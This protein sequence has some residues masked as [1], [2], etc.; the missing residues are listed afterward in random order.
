LNGFLAPTKITPQQQAPQTL[1][2]FSNSEELYKFMV[3]DNNLLKNDRTI[4]TSVLK[5]GSVDNSMQFIERDDSIEELCN[6]LQGRVS[7]TSPTKKE[8]N[9]II[10]SS[11]APGAGKSTFIEKLSNLSISDNLPKIKEIWKESIF[12]NVTFNAASELII[13]PNINPDQKYNFKNEFFRR[14]LWSYFLHCSFSEKLFQDYDI[15]DLNTEIVFDTIFYDMKNNYH[16]TRIFLCVDEIA[17]LGNNNVIYLCSELGKMLDTYGLNFNLFITSLD[18]VLLNQTT[19]A[20]GRSISYV[21]LPSL[22]EEGSLSLFSNSSNNITL[23]KM[24]LCCAGHPRTLSL[25]FNFYANNFN[26]DDFNTT[27]ARF[28]Q[29]R[30]QYFFVNEISVKY[31]LKAEHISVDEKIEN[32]RTVSDYVKDGYFLNSYERQ[33]TIVPYT[34]AFA[35]YK[36]A[37]ENPSSQF[38]HALFKIL[39]NNSDEGLGFEVFH[40]CWEILFR[41]V[42]PNK[43]PSYFFDALKDISLRSEPVSRTLKKLNNNFANFKGS[44]RHNNVP[45]KIM[46][47]FTSVIS[48]ITNNPGFDFLIFEEIKDSSNNV[49]TLTLTFEVKFSFSTDPNHLTAEAI[50]KKY[51]DTNDLFDPYLEPYLDKKKEKSD[52]FSYLKIIRFILI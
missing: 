50:V 20:T 27:F 6:Y 44:F 33:N 8:Q 34:S 47:Y 17:R 9:S 2:K 3:K 52:D 32:D 23:R 4:P 39:N 1:K 19:T 30:Y 21:Y 51:N 26:Y 11:A 31:V 22:S 15:S 29:Y 45:F 25:L 16:K 38:S 46:D 28:L 7:G 13:N 41:L 48:F 12:I 24:I 35:L 42:H 37:S 43:F 36:F 40:A 18:K 14:L 49:H 5:I 10:A